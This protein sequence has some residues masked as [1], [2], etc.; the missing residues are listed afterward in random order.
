[1][2]ITTFRQKLDD[3]H[4]WP[5]TYTY[6]F[7]VPNDEEKKTAVLKLFGETAKLA[8]KESG[9]GNYI[10][11]TAQR[12][13]LSSERIVDTYQEATKIKGLLAL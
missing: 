4:K 13:E 3:T 2:D 8:W 6:K 5:D 12:V 1:M 11:L 7:I 9:K 10:S